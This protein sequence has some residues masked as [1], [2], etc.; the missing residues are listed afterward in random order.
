M[1]LS[2]SGDRIV[3]AP[4]I[5]EL[6]TARRV[7][8]LAG[9]ER[10]LIAM[11]VILGLLAAAF[12]GI[13]LSALIP[14]ARHLVGMSVDDSIPVIGPFLVWLGTWMDI[15]G[16][17]ITII[18]F[19]M[20][21][22][23]VMVSFL[24]IIV[25][26]ILALEFAHSLRRRVFDS[27]LEKPLTEIKSLPSGKLVNDLASETWRTCDAVF[28]IVSA[29]IQIVTALVL[30]GFL[31]TLSP[32]YT[33]VLLSMTLA[34]ALI[35]HLATRA[36]RTLGAASVA[37]NQEF[38]AY[39]WDALGGLSTIR[40]FGRET[41]E[42]D[43]FD[44]R[45]RRVR[46]VFI[47]LNILSGSIGPL[48]QILSLLMVATLLALAILRGDDLTVLAGF[49][50]IAYRM[51]PR[52][53]TLLQARAQLRGLD[54]SV[55]AIETAVSDMGRKPKASTAKHSLGRLQGSIEFRNVTARYP[56]AERAALNDVS[57]TI[58]FGQT[59]AVAGYSGA[60]KSTLVALLLGFIRPEQG[61]I[62]VNGVPLSRIAP[63]AWQHRV[64]FVEQNAH[65]FNATVRENIGY[66]D[67]DADMDA[68]RAAAHIAQ[69][70]EFISSLDN[71]YETLIGESG[72]SL[73]Q[74]QRQRIALARALLRDPDILILDEATNALDRPTE[75]ALRRAVET[76]NKARA[77]IVIAHRREVIE[78]ADHVIVID[79]GRIVEDGT[80]AELSRAGRIYATLYL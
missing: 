28:V 19:G 12:E 46:D 38:M 54:A 29:V 30:L 24:N 2:C 71:G 16:I 57:C 36:V 61:A 79:S 58:F 41:Y 39:V 27:A 59:T 37:A 42:R 8:K 23:G 11:V 17:H 44:Q 45:S 1:A 67:L 5:S 4:M 13:G 77:V 76:G 80:P 26:N 73:S 3:K 53:T 14:L 32:F 25:S 9:P 55:M 70:D 21:I 52:I 63:E 47:R 6:S 68:I 7:L 10:R 20:F 43:R 50:A 40:G 69:A 64:A 66:G 48:T 33:A 74:G 72:T 56:G 51:Q 60:G 49:L 31:F 78:K 34:M 15:G 62:H 35:V 65:M 75:R 18:V 22:A